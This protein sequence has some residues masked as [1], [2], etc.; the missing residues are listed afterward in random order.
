M[1]SDFF[2]E[3][4]SLTKK[5]SIDILPFD[6]I[7]QEKDLYE[8]RRGTNHPAKRVRGGGTD[9]NAPTRFV[10]DPKNRGRWDGLLIMTVGECDSPGPSRV[11]RGYVLGKGQ[12]LYFNTSDIVIKM[13]ETNQVSGAWR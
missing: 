3:L 2:A 4:S 13:E 5:V 10:N 6:T 9:F 11:K 1:L 8:W 12:K 7:A